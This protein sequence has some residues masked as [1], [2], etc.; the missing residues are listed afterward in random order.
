MDFG[1][2]SD[3]KRNSDEIG[4]LWER[5]VPLER[6][7]DE[8][9]KKLSKQ[10]K[11]VSILDEK[12]KEPSDTAEEARSAFRSITQHRSRIMK[13]KS[14]ISQYHVE[15]EKMLEAVKAIDEDAKH[16]STKL[17]EI[18][19][20]SS[21]HASQIE[22][23]L[24]ESEELKSSLIA[25]TNRLNELVSNN[26]DLES[27]LIKIDQQV[28]DIN[29]FHSKSESMLKTVVSNHTKIRDLRDEIMGVRGR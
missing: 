25:N 27:N 24:K 6:E 22:V 29:E 26:K 7:L 15:A 19:N 4:K 3:S 18:N 23:L 28:T 11:K 1:M 10:E 20:S 13:M 5:L 17:A 12:I 9:K 8:H 2:F 21:E 16:Y 14:E